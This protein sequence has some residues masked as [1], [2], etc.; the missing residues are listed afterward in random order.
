MEDNLNKMK[1]KKPEEDLKKIKN[2]VLNFSQF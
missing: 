1:K 2:S